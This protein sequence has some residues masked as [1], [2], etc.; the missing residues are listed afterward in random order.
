MLEISKLESGYAGLQILWGVT[1]QIQ[2]GKITVVIGPN[3]AGKTTLLRTIMGI[4][5]PWKGKIEYNGKDV[6]WSPPHKKVELGLN[7]TP[8]GRRLF[9]EM[10]VSENLKMGA[11]SKRARE[12]APE[13]LEIV[14]NLFSPRAGLKV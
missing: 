5:K 8:E 3:G 13:T 11:Y 10:T 1:L 12:K 7:L 2:K 6:T 14:F 9:P 4:V